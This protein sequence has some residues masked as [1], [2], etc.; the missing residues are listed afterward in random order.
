[1]NLHA[2]GCSLTHVDSYYI[3]WTVCPENSAVPGLQCD[4]RYRNKGDI[5]TLF[6]GLE[7]NILE[8]YKMP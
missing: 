5:Y 3:L 2:P 6:E 7:E 1:M 4:G 8:H